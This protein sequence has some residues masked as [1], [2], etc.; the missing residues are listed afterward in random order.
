MATMKRLEAALSRAGRADVSAAADAA[1]GRLAEQAAHDGLLD[2]A[3]TTLDSPV[4][5]VLVAATQR[6]LVRISFSPHYD[7]DEVLV[8]LSERIS[9]RVIEAPSYFDSVRRELEEYFEG[10][11]TSFGLPLDWR[12]T[13]GFGRRVLKHTARI[14]YG[15]VSTYKEMAAAAGSPRG[16]RAAGNALGSNP[17]PIVVPC[18]RVL[19]SGGGLGGYGGGIENKVLLLKLEGAIGEDE[20]PPVTA[21]RSAASPRPPVAPRARRGRSRDPGSRGRSSRKG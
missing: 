14:P 12:L 1:A 21:S 16:A 18:H 9:P 13:G 5:P 6:G 19:H 10:R 20:E 2:V 3:Y 4:G 15:K 8:E 11:R 17:I 7:H